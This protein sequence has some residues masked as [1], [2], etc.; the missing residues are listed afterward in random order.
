MTNRKARVTVV[1]S[2]R[3][4][5]CTS[6]T[7]A[8]LSLQRVAVPGAPS[9]KWIDLARN[10]FLTPRASP[11]AERRRLT[12]G[13]PQLAVKT[14]QPLKSTLYPSS[15][16]HYYAICA[17]LLGLDPRSRCARREANESHFRVLT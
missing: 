17:L 6:D 7:P 14:A 11:S 4:R 10:H 2:N 12:T 9:C 8:D 5:S 1:T 15:R 13:P 3:A 16:L